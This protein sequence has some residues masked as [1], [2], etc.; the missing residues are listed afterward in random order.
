LAKKEELNNVIHIASPE[1]FLRI[2]ARN[3]AK[4]AKKEEL[5]N[6]M[7]LAIFEPFLFDGPVRQVN[8]IK[9]LADRRHPRIPEI[10]VYAIQW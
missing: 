6:I 1:S 7:Y 2:F 3:Y 4:T 5:N 10:R 9:H 8:T